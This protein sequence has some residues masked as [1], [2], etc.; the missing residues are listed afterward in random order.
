MKTAPLLTPEQVAAQLQVART[1][2]LAMLRTG[3]LVGVK[4]GPQWRIEPTAIDQF[5]V[6]H[7][8]APSRP[9]VMFGVESAP[10][11]A[12]V[13]SALQDLMPKA[14]RFS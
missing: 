5:V 12:T 6:A 11:V 3:R 10:G 2:V 1:T 4:V 14:R 7:R 13:R 9:A 8:Q